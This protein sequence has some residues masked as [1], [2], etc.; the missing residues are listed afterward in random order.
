MKFKKERDLQERKIDFNFK[1]TDKNNNKL[2][3]VCN[4][5]VKR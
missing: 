3:N 1:Q 5:N 2:E 4:L